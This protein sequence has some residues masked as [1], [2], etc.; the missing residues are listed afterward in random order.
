MSLKEEVTGL[1]VP[2]KL[3]YALA[4]GVPLLVIASEDSE[5]AR[6][7]RENGCGWN[8]SP[9]NV[10]A[11]V[12]LFKKISGEPSLLNEKRQKAR[13]C[14]EKY[15]TRQRALQQYESIFSGA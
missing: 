13:A 12:D 7:V 8:I 2:G 5:P 10:G 11:V 15:F 9:G 3:Y 14:F 1:C 6:I 4:A